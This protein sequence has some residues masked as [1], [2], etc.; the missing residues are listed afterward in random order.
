MKRENVY[1]EEV[2]HISSW[3]NSEKSSVIN[4]PIIRATLTDHV[5]R[6]K[7]CEKNH[8]CRSCKNQTL[9]KVNIEPFFFC[10]NCFWFGHKENVN[11]YSKEDEDLNME[12]FAMPD[13]LLELDKSD[14]NETKKEISKKSESIEYIMS[15]VRNYAEQHKLF[16]NIYK[17]ELVFDS[18]FVQPQT[19]DDYFPKLFASL[20]YY[21]RGGYSYFSV[22]NQKSRASHSKHMT[23]DVL[24]FKKSDEPLYFGGVKSSISDEDIKKYKL[25]LFKNEN[26]IIN[27][28]CRFIDFALNQSNTLLYKV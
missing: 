10:I 20:T 26:N 28:F 11:I 22:T 14:S 16:C 5:E 6:Y 21:E 13:D 17:S 1:G 18:I 19:K 9:I 27:D 3:L 8:Y 4:N 24:F 7:Q 23:S 15:R 12:C 2:N 25:P